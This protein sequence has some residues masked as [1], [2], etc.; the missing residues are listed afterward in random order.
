MS[1]YVVIKKSAIQTSDYNIISKLYKR[2]G[3][4]VTNTI[5]LNGST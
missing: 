1:Y 4:T 3:L 5:I 2:G